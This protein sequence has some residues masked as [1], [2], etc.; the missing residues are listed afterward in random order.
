[1]DKI[2]EVEIIRLEKKKFRPKQKPCFRSFFRKIKFWLPKGKII[3]SNKV[4]EIILNTFGKDYYYHILIS[5]ERYRLMER[6]QLEELLKKD[7]TDQ[8]QYIPEDFDCNNFAEVLD[9]NI[10]EL[11]YPQGYA[12]GQLWFYTNE[13]GHAINFAILED[14]SLVLIEPQNDEIFTWE[15][16]KKQYPEARAFMVKI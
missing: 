9:G 7:K 13:F 4:L 11:T 5:D 6:K 12:F 15:D 10:D 2:G 8:Y 3:D 1:M 16:I 14:E